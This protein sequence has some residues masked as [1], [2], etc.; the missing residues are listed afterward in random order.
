MKNLIIILTSIVSFIMGCN[1]TSLNHKDYEFKL[2]DFDW[3]KKIEGQVGE[4]YIKESNF[5]YGRNHDSTFLEISPKTG[6]ILNTLQP[7]TIEKEREPLIL[8][9][10]REFKNG[11]SLY[12]VPVDKQKY[13]K[14]TLKVFDRQYRGDTE[15][16]Y[17][18]INTLTNQEFTILFNREQFTFISDI[19]YFRDGKFV[20]T[21]N[22]ESA[23][24]YQKYFNYV[25]LIDLEKIMKK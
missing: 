13:S 19:T 8:D 3:N 11:Y 9:S 15:T 23:T 24:D 25:G 4:I 2:H 1:M 14:V 16:F 5:I 12:N 17:L 10:A 18:I 6:A 22:G 21:F 20:L 7:Y